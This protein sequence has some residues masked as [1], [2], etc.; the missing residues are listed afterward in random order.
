MNDSSQSLLDVQGLRVVHGAGRRA[1]DRLVAVDDVSLRVY[2]GE[3]VGLVGE[4]GCGKSSMAQ[5]LTGQVV[6]VSGTVAWRGEDMSGV[7]GKR[8]VR[9]RI[10]MI[11]Q[12]VSG[13]LN[14]RLTIAEA[15]SEVLS[16][17]QL[18][19]ATG[20][21]QQRVAELL[22]LVGLPESAGHRYPHEFSGGQRQRISIARALAVEPELLIAD[23]PVSALDVSVQVQVIDVLRSLREQK[24]L[25]GLLIAHDLAVVS[26]LC[27]RVYVMYLGRIM[28]WGP[29]ERVLYAPRHPYTRAL[30]AAVPDVE[31]GLARRRASRPR[32]L[33]EGDVPSRRHEFS[34][35][36]FQGRCPLVAEICRKEAPDFVLMEDGSRGSACWFSRDI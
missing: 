9:R 17:H 15:I 29:V 32:D 1:L 22:Q 10:Q 3:W 5:A 33:L 23:E 2:P 25:A 20:E 19:S 7:L 27:A 21:L 24:R 36:P 28:E 26:S 6:P 4:S 12:D 35:C 31:R 34:G 14:P 13:A 18:A 11:F 16:V 30:L 8:S